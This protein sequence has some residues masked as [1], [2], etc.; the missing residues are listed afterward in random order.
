MNIQF[1]KF[2]E[3]YIDEAVQLALAELCAERVHCPELPSHGVEGR[4]REILWW[5]GSQSF[6]KAAGGFAGNM[7]VT[8]ILLSRQLPDSL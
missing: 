4:L 3:K 5:L 6:G 1:E 7:G 8:I 2:T